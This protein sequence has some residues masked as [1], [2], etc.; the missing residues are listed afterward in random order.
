MHPCIFTVGITDQSRPL[1]P[2]TGFPTTVLVPS[3]TNKEEI[4]PAKL[5]RMD[6]PPSMSLTCLPWYE[7]TSYIK[8]IL[9]YK[10]MVNVLTLIRDTDSS[11]YVDPRGTKTAVGEAGPP[12]ITYNFT[13]K[14]KETGIDGIILACKV[15]L[16]GGCR[17][18]IPCIPLPTNLAQFTVPPETT[19]SPTTTPEFQ[20]YAAAL[21]RYGIG[22]GFVS[23]H[24]MG[25]ARWGGSAADGSVCDGK[26]G[27]KVW[28][29]EGV[30]VVDG[31]AFPTASGVNPML[32]IM[33]LAEWAGRRI[34]EQIRVKK[35]GEYVAAT[36]LGRA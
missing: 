24:L 2:W 23:G 36:T 9:S 19:S 18:V 17:T 32:T 15:L 5:M 29:S 26:K 3:S 31:S 6:P 12:D 14:D 34:V 25:T 33:T 28:G 21:K 35:K 10:H 30:Y 8:N 1:N 7:P 27:G 13:K 4:V 16:E 22:Q 20:A 11:G